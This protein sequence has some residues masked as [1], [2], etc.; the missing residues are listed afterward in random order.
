MTRKELQAADIAHVMRVTGCTEE[1][2][3]DNLI[4]DEWSIWWAVAHIRDA[5]AR[6][7]Y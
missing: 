2:A 1:Q 7:V 5:Q 4:A 6:G 3:R